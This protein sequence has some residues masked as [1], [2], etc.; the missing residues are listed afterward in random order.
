[1][2]WTAFWSALVGGGI[3]VLVQI[4]SLIGQSKVDAQ[5]HA[6][7][8][9]AAK[10]ARDDEAAARRQD[11]ARARTV[12]LMERVATDVQVFVAE[13]QEI[14][15]MGVGPATANRAER[16]AN[17]IRRRHILA[18]PSIVATDV[19]EEADALYTKWGMYAVMHEDLAVQNIR[20]E[21]TAVAEAARDALM[22]FMESARTANSLAA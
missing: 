10:S 9:A 16:L 11:D 18:T 15:Q 22:T 13:A 12:Q 6:R 21:D 5:R 20:D 14:A 19:G 1:M 8:T 17:E 2:D 3:A 7:E 4:V